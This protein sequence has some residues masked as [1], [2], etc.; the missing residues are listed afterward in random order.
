MATAEV[1]EV[2]AAGEKRSGSSDLGDDMYDPF[3]FESCNRGEEGG[4]ESV[5]G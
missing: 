5:R 4:R 2:E 1:E 3:V